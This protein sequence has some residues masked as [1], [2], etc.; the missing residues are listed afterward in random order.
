MSGESLN[1]KRATHPHWSGTL[2]LD[3]F[4]GRV[5]LKEFGSTGEYK[6]DQRNNILHVFWDEFPAESFKE[7][8]GIYVKMFGAEGEIEFMRNFQ[9]QRLGVRVP[10]GGANIELRI[11]TTDVD[12]FKQVFVANEY[13]IPSL[14][15]SCKN[16]IDLGA[17]IGC[18]AVYF[19]ERYP[20][21]KILAVEP[22]EDN[23][24]LLFRNAE[25]FEGRITCVRA[26]IWSCAQRVHISTHDSGGQ[27]LGAWGIRVSGDAASDSVTI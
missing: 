14:P 8:N 23:Y 24:R 15:L 17:N 1:V 5:S 9:I 6:L 10:G 25:Q 4:T 27:A 3:E 26:A 21:A 19:A 7:V 22:D 11:G 2:V 18:S 13:N 20:G 12:T 16:I